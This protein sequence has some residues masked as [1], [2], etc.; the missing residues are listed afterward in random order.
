MLKNNVQ[1]VIQD[2]SAECGLACISYISET[3]GKKL[4]LPGLRNQYDV[5][6]EGLSFF[7]LIKILSEHQ[8]IA[9]GVNAPADSLSELQIP[10][11]LLWDN[12]H[13]VVLKKVSKT[14]IEV[15]DPAVGS[16][17]FTRQ[18]VDKFYSGVAL[19]VTPDESFIADKKRSRADAG[20]DDSN[21]FGLAAFRKGLSAYKSYL[22]PLAAM[23]VIIQLTNIAVPKFISLVFDEVL[24]KNDEDFLYLLIYIFGFVYL[25]QAVAGYLKISVAQRLR[26]TLSQTEGLKTVKNLFNM[27]LKYFHKRMPSDLLRKIKSV[28]VFHVIYTNGWIDI[29]IQAVFAGLFVVLLF[30][31]N[32]ELAM[33]TGALTSVMI[34]IRVLLIPSLMSRQY[35]SIDAEVRRDNVLLESVDNI[36]VVKINHNEHRRILDWSVNH[37][38]L[39][40]NRSSIEKTNA[41]IEL[42]LTTIS[43]IQTLLIMGMGSLSVLKGESSAGQLISFI[44]YKNCLMTNIQSI[45]ESHVNIKICSVEVKRLRDISPVIQEAKIPYKS[46]TENRQEKMRTISFRDVCFSYSNLDDNFINNVNFEL[47]EG[48]KMVITGPSG[49]G[50][51]TIINLLAGLLMPT[52]GMILVNDIPLERFG[53]YEL[54][55]QISLVSAEGKLIIGNV[56]DNIVFECDHYDMTLLEKCI[57]QADLGDV[58]RSLKAGLNTRLGTNGAK[59]SSGQHQRLMIARALYRKPQLI[60]LDEPTS[61][62]DAEARDKIIALINSLNIACVVVSHDALLIDTIENRVVI[63]GQGQ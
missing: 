7:H 42:S 63:S 19:E 4:S 21:F 52:S 1:D 18:E 43:H 58:V 9:T 33:L 40:Y 20:E 53:L 15:M 6:L 62:L 51:T 12:C 36:N 54:Q 27:E 45:V 49:C 3:Y 34:L 55:Q 38:E 46:S 5:T 35:S 56:I 13:F 61:H 23:A 29:F 32:A 2:E 8:M 47:L 30:F 50:K 48:Q 10:A 11:I 24:P 39:E 59:L 31:I 22:V 14:R 16:R 41:L 25:M 57:E 44:F 60:L 26:R 28:D 17:T 37:A